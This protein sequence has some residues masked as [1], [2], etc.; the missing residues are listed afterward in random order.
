MTQGTAPETVAG[1]GTALLTFVQR[2]L[3]PGASEVTI[4]GLGRTTGGQSREN[5]PF[6]LR[7]RDP[8]GR[9]VE[10]ALIMR[11]DPTGSVLDTD[12]AD[13]HAVLRAIEDTAVPS[14]RSLWLDAT[15]EALGRPAVVM[16]RYDGLN[17]HFV[18]EGG[19]SGFDVETRVALAHRFCEVMTEIHR[20]DWRGL[21]LGDHLAD[22]GPYASLAA[23]DHWCATLD[24]HRLEPLP[25][26]TDV[27]CWLRERAPT[28]QAV[29]LVHGD[30]KP[31]NALLDGSAVQV[32]LDWETAHLGD[33]IEDVGWVTNPLRRREHLIAE[34]WE[35]DD[36]VGHYESLTGFTVPPRELHWWNV[37]A[38][39]K[40]SVIVLTG[41]RSFCEGTSDRVWTTPRS[42]C[43]LLLD[44][45]E[46]EEPE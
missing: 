11:R 45:I 39:F 6:D 31:G 24:R 34:R 15:G 46:R 30:L 26:M 1:V 40:L 32:M 18:L 9:V 43:R 33:P 17:D 2:Q 19:I 7:W 35:R 27:E 14:P 25:E 36:L 16:E 41:A 20:V 12:R 28:A 37:L 10:Q 8:D 29:V 42:L 4:S 44:W 23:L 3:G 22:P 5:W 13:E 38:T 21:G